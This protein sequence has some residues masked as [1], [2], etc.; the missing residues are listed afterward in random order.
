MNLRPYQTQAIEMARAAF[1]SGKRAVL[2]V[3]PTGA[4]KTV[5]AGEVIRRAVAK[6]GRVVFVGHRRE[7]ISQCS[8]RL[9]AIGVEHGIVAADMP[10]FA[11]HLPVQVASVQTL[12]ARPDDRPPASLLIMDEAHHARAGSFATLMDAYGDKAR[13]LGLTATPIRL[14]NK[15]LGECFDAMVQVAQPPELIRD[16]FLVP[17]DGYAYQTADLRDVATRGSDYDQAQLGAKMHDKRI[18]GDIVSEWRAHASRLLTVMFAVHVAHS[19][20][21]VDAFNQA[22]VAAAHIDGSM[23]NAN[24]D[25]ILARWRAGEIR[26]VS[27]CQVLG[28]GY[29][30]PQIGCVVLAAP[31]QSLSLFLQRVGRGMRPACMACGKA[32]DPRLPTC[33]HC[34][35][36][37]VKRTARLH[38]HSG[39]VAAFNLPDIARQWTLDRDGYVRDPADKAI[40]VR[41]CSKCFAV[42]RP[43][44]PACPR[45]GWR[46]AKV[47]REIKTADGVAISLAEAAARAQP[48]GPVHTSKENKQQHYFHL[49]KICRLKGRKIGWASH[50]FRG[51]YNE[52]PPR[53]WQAEFEPWFAA[54]R[55]SHP[56]TESAS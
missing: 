38:D 17:V 7:L 42:Y 44:L 2:L 19:E 22:G 53:E 10:G 51:K 26:V 55:K 33:Q 35:S 25:S 28:E 40:G 32:T 20:E 48:T 37:D 24:R 50:C 39:G 34:G 29:D 18:I 31:T 3:A 14:D 41:T 30:L 15:G 21:L 52:W 47:L 6:G 9:R 1:G 8:A 11:P 46:N 16:G 54:W 12:R 45:C 56:E 43:T 13:I 5:C 36:P 4:G 27:N 23:S 49:L